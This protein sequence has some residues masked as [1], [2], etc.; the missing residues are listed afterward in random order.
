MECVNSFIVEN[1][2]KIGKFIEDLGCKDIEVSI[3]EMCS[4]SATFIQVLTPVFKESHHSSA[5]FGLFD[6]LFS[7]TRMSRFIEF[8]AVHF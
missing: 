8:I 2:S 7:D 1:K 3:C 4:A 5:K 6:P